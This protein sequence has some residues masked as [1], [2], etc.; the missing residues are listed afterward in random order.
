M[1]SFL[2]VPLYTDVMPAAG[3]GSLTIIF[4]FFALFNVVL[5]YGMETAFFRFYNNE[6]HPES[7]LAT[8]QITLLL[9]T[10]GFLILGW[11]FS[12]PLSLIL[13]IEP[14]YFSYF[15][16]ILALDALVI[17]P[18]AHLRAKEQPGKYALIKLANVGINIGL[19]LYFLLLL[20]KLGGAQEVLH[21][22]NTDRQI[23]YILLAML[24]SSGTTLLL[25]SKSYITI[26]WRFNAN[27]AWRML[28]YG[29]PVMIAGIAFTINEVFDKYLLS[30]L[31][32][33]APEAARA[34]VGKYAACYKLAMFMT[35][36]GT[37]FRLGIE[38]FFFAHAK[39]VNPQQSY[40]QITK[41]FVVLG[42]FILLGVVVF[43]DLIKGVIIRDPVFWEAMEVVPVILTASLFLGIYHNLSV[44]Y[45]IT[46]RTRF[47]AIISLIGAALTIAINVIYI[48]IYG[49]MAS[50]WATLAAYGS[51]M[52]LS[53]LLGKKFYPIPYN[54]RKIGLYLGFSIGCSYLYFYLFND[55]IF[56]GAG[57]IVAYLG[58][59]YTQE[60]KQLNQIIR[61]S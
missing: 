15:L 43:S 48:P 29:F 35:L 6:E 26:S 30:E 45:K 59:V 56:L 5:A 2:L 34:E 40:A 8:S 22:G 52:L 4:T 16:G 12:T 55:N 33:L 27:L 24:V 25:L 46:D 32:P 37:A 21:L 61:K 36:F 57:L 47:G 58:V 39:A 14:I 9:S 13:N 31:L 38:P 1:L 19:N 23:H 44:W 51:M 54:T 11:L 17:V 50:A 7:V 41:Y 49:Y 10:G 18:F 53:Y 42:G 20:P 28:Q 60:W 3:Y